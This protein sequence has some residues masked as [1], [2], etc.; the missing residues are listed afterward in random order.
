[1][2]IETFNKIFFNIIGLPCSGTTIVSKFFDSLDNGQCFSEPLHSLKVDASSFIPDLKD[3][4]SKS[5]FSICGIKEVFIN[6]IGRDRLKSIE[7]NFDLFDLCFVVLRDPVENISSIC[8][9]MKKLRNREDFFENLIKSY[10]RLF[11]F[12]AERK[13]HIISYER[14]CDNPINEINKSLVGKHIVRGEFKLK[15]TYD[16]YIIGN[17][18]ARKS[19][20][21]HSPKT[22]QNA[23][24][25][26][27]KQRIILEI[28][29][30][31]KKI[32]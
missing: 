14:F 21:I 11:S 22:R 6:N 28:L 3:Q 10:E 8:S 23:I 15:T 12:V 19:T 16:N 25:E 30:T 17:P 32:I 2:K 24:S 13:P 9:K 27:E 18:V 29:P 5:Q 4:F 26:E 20:I 7:N 31:Y 1:M